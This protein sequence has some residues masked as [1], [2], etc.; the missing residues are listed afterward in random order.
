MGGKKLK[1]VKSIFSSVLMKSKLRKNW[2]FKSMF[3][4]GLSYFFFF[5]G[6]GHLPHFFLHD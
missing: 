6:G 4:V 3:L 1:N 5:G 2:F